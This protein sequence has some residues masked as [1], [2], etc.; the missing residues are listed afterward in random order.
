MILFAS[1]KV[2]I[3]NRVFDAEN[4]VET[5]N[6]TL[7]LS[8]LVK[9]KGSNITKTG[10]ENADTAKL[11][12]DFQIGSKVYVEPK[13]YEALADKSTAFTFAEGV[14]FFVEG[15]LSEVEIPEENAFEYFLENYDSVFR[16]TTVDQ[17]KDVMPHIEVGGE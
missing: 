6:K 11:Y 7:A 1:D 3:F 10:L 17:Y 2:T 14:D 13:A 16:V 15:D 12:C 5:W 4:E 8:N 9:T